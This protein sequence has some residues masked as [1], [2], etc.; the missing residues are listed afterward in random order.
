[1]TFIIGYKMLFRKR[2][3]ASSILAVALLFA[4]SPP[5]TPQ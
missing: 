2:G 1:M 5:Q 3:A 4:V